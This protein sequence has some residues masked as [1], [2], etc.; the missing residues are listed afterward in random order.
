MGHNEIF[1]EKKHDL[2]NPFFSYEKKKLDFL[3]LELR[4]ICNDIDPYSELTA[5]MKNRLMAVN[6]T[7]FTNPY[8][9]TNQL[10]FMLENALEAQLKN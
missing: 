9:L 1:S 2:S 10:I 8:L 4:S 5:E 7:D 6:I 3:I